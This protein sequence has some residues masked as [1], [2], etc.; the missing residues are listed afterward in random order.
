MLVVGLTG[1]IASGKST[2]SRL[3]STKHKFPIV[4]ADVIARDVV[5]PG[6]SAHKKIIKHF[7]EDVLLKDGSRE[8]D[9]KKLGDVIFRDASKR[10]V[11]NGIVHPAVRWAMFTAVIKHWLSGESV[12]ILDV[13]LLVEAN[14][15]KWVGWVVV[16][17]CSREIQTKRL[18]DRDNITVSAAQDRLSSQMAL[19]DKVG[20]AD[21]VIDNSSGVIELERQVA[22]LAASLRAKAGWSWRL[23]WLVP[24]AGVLLAIWSLASRALLRYI[25]NKRAARSRKARL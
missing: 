24:P 19:T 8:L 9:R 12:C 5:Q 3:L 22:E 7:G 17:Y 20:Y 4:D 25:G 16:I 21:K 1:G 11:L 15:W 23:A 18:I 10:K 6:T 14:L 13:P 2:V